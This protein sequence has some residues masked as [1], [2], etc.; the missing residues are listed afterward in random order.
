MLVGFLF[1]DFS[2]KIAIDRF[3]W[4]F[5]SCI[6]NRMTY[7]ILVIFPKSAKLNPYQ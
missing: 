3:Y 4:Q 6:S 7:F 5:D 2:K 1:G